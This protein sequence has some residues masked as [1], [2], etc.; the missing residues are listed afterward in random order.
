MNES[1]TQ[2]LSR[3][4]LM[5][6]MLGATMTG[7]VRRQPYPRDSTLIVAGSYFGRVFSPAVGSDAKHLIFLSLAAWGANGSLEGRLAESWEPSPDYGEWTYRLRRNVRWHDGV[8]VTAHD[9]KFTFDLEIRPDVGEES[10]SLFQSVE[11]LDDWTVRI[12]SVNTIGYLIDNVVFPRHLLDK[13]EPAKF[14]EWDFWSHPVGD[15]P[16]RFQRA[17][18]NVMVELQANSDFYRGK[19]AIERVVL[20]AVDTRSRGVISELTSGA[21]DLLED[22]DPAQ[23]PLLH[24]EPRLRAYFEIV[25][26]VSLAIFW[27]TRR[28]L[29]RDARMRRALTLAIDRR[30]LLSLLNWPGDLPIY[31]GPLMGHQLHRQEWLSPLPYDPAQ[32]RALLE[33]AGWRELGGDGVRENE[34]HELRFTALVPPGG[35]LLTIAT[36][37]QDRL[38]RVGVRM[39]LLPLEG[40]SLRA[41]MNDGAFDAAFGGQA[42]SPEGLRRWFGP[43]S[44]VYANP[45]IA[46]L[47]ADAQL[48][49][50]PAAQDRIYGQLM[51]IWRADMPAT[52]LFPSVGTLF[53][54][55]RVQ[56]LSS[57]WRGNPMPRM[58]ELWLSRS[59]Q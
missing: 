50:V 6:G 8:P 59:A 17:I 48:T 22:A 51:D 38:R 34:G 19:P 58:D 23:I 18:P 49:E 41:R 32:A 35:P 46:R 4:E 30:E 31:D 47:V 53:A 42:T 14:R 25:A 28:G 24:S 9:V 56:G 45:A 39:D 1:G 40:A 37:V 36:Y 55:R 27:Q 26:W 52:F 11:V 43:S 3:R 12:R 16:Y 33:Q 7:C 20:K 13:L 2:L 57:P 29:L 15:G 10:P 44:K 54:H 21:V 5:F